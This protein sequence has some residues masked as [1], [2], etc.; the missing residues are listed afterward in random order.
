MATQVAATGS[1]PKWVAAPFE[2]HIHSAHYYP[3]YQA[4]VDSL[5]HSLGHLSMQQHHFPEFLVP[6]LQVV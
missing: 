2:L 5:T 3:D 4:T 6:N 1:V